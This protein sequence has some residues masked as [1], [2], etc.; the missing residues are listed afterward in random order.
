MEIRLT[1]TAPPRRA[2][3]TGWIAALILVLGIAMP[4][5]LTRPLSPAEAEARIRQHLEWQEAQS[6]G[7][8]L[9]AQGR[10][11]PDAA[12][13]STWERRLQEVQAIEFVSVEVRR[14]LWVRSFRWRATTVARV[15]TRGRDRDRV[16][17][18]RIDRLGLVRECPSVEWFIRL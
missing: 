11:T 10:S 6:L 14:S 2:R 18:F 9:R 15:V 3:L 7:E 16:R 13:A 1:L 4:A 12:T 17:I 5:L 8:V